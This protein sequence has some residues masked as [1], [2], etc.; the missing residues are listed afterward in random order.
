MK[1][2]R[3]HKWDVTPAEARKIQER[4]RDEVTIAPLKNEPALAA[5]AD[6]SFSRRSDRLFAGIVVLRLSDMET[7]ETAA[8]ETQATFPYIPG[9]LSF[10]EIP[11]LIQLFRKLKTN[12]DVLICDGQG[13][14]HP[15]FFGLACHL[16]LTLDIPTVGCAKTLLVGEYREP[17]DSP[18]SK[19]PLVYQDRQVGLVVRSRQGVK[20]IFISPGHKIDFPGAVSLVKR[21]TAKFRLPE[22]TRRAHQ[23]VNQIRVSAGG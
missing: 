20:P 2:R 4:L 18:W 11:P 10:R 5:G 22:T 12:P 23:L 17:A 6:I 9:Y 15:R 19:S 1:I 21:C 16:G 8:V 13:L 14:A 3:L 7:V